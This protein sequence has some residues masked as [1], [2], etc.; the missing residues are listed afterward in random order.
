MK[1][2]KIC[3]MLLLI[4]IIV[5][6][7]CDDALSTENWSLRVLPDYIEMVDG[8]YPEELEY[9]VKAIIEIDPP[10]DSESVFISDENGYF[11]FTTIPAGEYSIHIPFTDGSADAD[12]TVSENGIT[13]KTPLVYSW[14]VI[15]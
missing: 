5:L 7:A 15:L 14:D 11:E 9:P 4:L 1:K 8:E 6:S 13:R 10:I 3:I 2:N 12:I